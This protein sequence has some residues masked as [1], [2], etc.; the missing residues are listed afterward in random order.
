MGADRR[1][2]TN[3]HQLPW[4]GYSAMEMSQIK[5]APR[6]VRQLSIDAGRPFDVL[7]SAYE[8]A[9]PPFDYLE[10]MGVDISGGGWDGIIRLSETTAVHGLVNFFTFDPSPV[11]RL[12]GSSRRAVTYMSGNL[13]RMDPGFRVNPSCLLYVPLRLV[14]V[15]LDDDN[16]ELSLDLPSDLLIPLAEEMPSTVGR[17]FNHVL[18]DLFQ[19]LALP[20]PSE[21]L[22]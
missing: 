10:A 2:Q 14:I 6:V 5:V 16:S 13:V 4:R 15:E 9:V 20:V 8:R 22:E 19:H 7:R 1:P 21:L 17:D 12:N 18:A 11:M 3:D